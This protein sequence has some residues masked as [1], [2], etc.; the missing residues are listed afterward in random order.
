MCRR[1]DPELSE[2]LEL[3]VWLCTLILL[4]GLAHLFLS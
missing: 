1:P 2:L 4:V 3:V